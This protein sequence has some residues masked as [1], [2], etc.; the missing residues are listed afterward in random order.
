MMNMAFTNNNSKGNDE[1]LCLVDSATMYTIMKDKKY[2]SN[3]TLGTTNINTISG[4]TNL[5]EGFGG[6]NIMLS[7]GTQF[8][9]HDA[10]LSSRSRKNLLSFKDIHRKGIILRLQMRIK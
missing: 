2:F 5:I 1:E 10:L 9:I 3:L 6:A 8:V 7:G 4:S